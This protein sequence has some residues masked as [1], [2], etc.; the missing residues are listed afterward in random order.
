MIELEKPNGRLG[1]Y[2]ITCWRS[3]G[4]V[5]KRPTTTPVVSVPARMGIRVAA[6]MLID[7]YEIEISRVHRAMA[8][9]KYLMFLQGLQDDVGRDAEARPPT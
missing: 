4:T 3:A 6:D 7:K 9:D 5:L 8:V 1:R 2:L